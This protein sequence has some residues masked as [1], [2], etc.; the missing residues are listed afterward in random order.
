MLPPSSL[1]A[2]DTPRGGSRVGADVQTLLRRS[3]ELDARQLL[4]EQL[5]CRRIQIPQP[6]DL[7]LGEAQPRDLEI[8]G[9]NQLQPIRDVVNWNGGGTLA[10]KWTRRHSGS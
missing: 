3:E 5:A 2:E 8:F 6:L 4:E 9:T 1:L 7:P 10:L